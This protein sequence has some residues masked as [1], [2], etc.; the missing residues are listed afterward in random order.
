MA[1]VQQHHV[2]C[3]PGMFGF[4][5]LAGYDY[6][7]HVKA[8]IAPHFYNA[9]FDVSF[10]DVP[11]PPTSSLRERAKV[12]MQTV[13]HTSGD[14]GPIHIL[15]HST[16]GLDARLALAPT[17]HVGVGRD[18]LT[19]RSR[20]ATLV[21]M[22]TPHY[23]TPLSS[24]F[25]TVSGARM[26]YALSVL[27]AVSL[28]LG[29]PS[30]SILSRLL[31]AVGSFDSWLGGDMKLFSKATDG[32]LRF[33]D[34]EGRREITDYLSKVRTDQG[35][36]IQITPEAMDLFNAAVE[37][38]EHV[39]YGCIVAAAPSPSTLKAARRVR[40]PYMAMTAALYT[41]LY[42][43]TAQHHER[44]GYAR[45]NDADLTALTQALGKAPTDEHNDGIVPSLSMLWGKLIWS[46][47]ADHLDTLGHFHDDQRP[48]I[49]TDWLTSGA[50]LN[51][52]R[53]LRMMTAIARFQ[54]DGAQ[55]KAISSGHHD[56]PEPYSG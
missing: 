28:R 15:G 9:G 20:V 41:T 34:K 30:L 24:Y 18:L 2:Y 23:G 27:T 10:Y 42:Q 12:L 13:L 14:S 45:P 5:Q 54:L 17:V 6:F 22:N 49:H 26:L 32:I 51:R 33:V 38:A 36:I 8:A 47:D 48:T 39:R 21:T 56:R 53:F 46:E 29:A 11:S 35:A 37:N 44:Y 16:G 3:V 40:G 1:E 7:Q 55:A 52:S 25:A 31:T 4:G 19:W 43:I 50:H